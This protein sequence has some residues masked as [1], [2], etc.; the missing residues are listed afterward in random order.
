MIP[1]HAARSCFPSLIRFQTQEITGISIL[2]KHM[3]TQHGCQGHDL[4]FWWRI[5]SLERP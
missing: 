3:A 4:S 2:H 5:E 1:A